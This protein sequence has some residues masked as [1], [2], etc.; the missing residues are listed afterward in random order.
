MAMGMY[1]SYL[2]SKTV[3]PSN[4][5]R[6]VPKKVA[7]APHCGDWTKSIS[8]TASLS[9][10]AATASSPEG[11]S[12]STVFSPSLTTSSV[13]LK[14]RRQ[15]LIARQGGGKE[16]MYKFTIVHQRI[17]SQQREY[18]LSEFISLC[19]PVTSAS[20]LAFDFISVHKMGKQLR[21]WIRSTTPLVCPAITEFS[22]SIAETT[23]AATTIKHIGRTLTNRYFPVA[24]RILIG[25]RVS[26][27]STAATTT[28]P[29]ATATTS[30]TSCR[31]GFC[32]S[33]YI[34]IEALKCETFNG[35]R[36]NQ[37]QLAVE[38]WR[39]AWA[40]QPP[41]SAIVAPLLPPPVSPTNPR[42]SSARPSAAEQQSAATDHPYRYRPANQTD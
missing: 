35:E 42:F 15:K 20:S 11:F 21:I 31:F 25:G 41:C 7:M 18:S 29:V 40:L 28:T 38:A 22:I 5:S 2:S 37:P 30:A 36:A 27:R 17:L 24:I 33:Y 13:T 26:V 32:L 16:N 34:E 9:P 8:S 14:Q 23:L 6:V 12:T 39:E 10:S 19:S 1:A 4:V 3:F